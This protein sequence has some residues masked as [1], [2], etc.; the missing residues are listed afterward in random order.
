MQILLDA[1]GFIFFQT[2]YKAICRAVKFW[3]MRCGTN[4][5]TLTNDKWKRL[6]VAKHE[7]LTSVAWAACL[8][9]K[10]KLDRSL[11]LKPQQNKFKLFHNKS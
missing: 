7:L 10:C 2:E 4:T 6:N 1:N 5:C 3:K 9:S 11:T 8:P